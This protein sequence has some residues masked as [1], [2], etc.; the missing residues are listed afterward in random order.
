MIYEQNGANFP[1]SGLYCSIFGFMEPYEQGL[2]SK[3]E[4]IF[5]KIFPKMVKKTR[6]FL[7]G[8]GRSNSSLDWP[9]NDLENGN[10]DLN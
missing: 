3:M 10:V 1:G 5:W 2:W 9:E 8:F 4:Q 6:S 7:F